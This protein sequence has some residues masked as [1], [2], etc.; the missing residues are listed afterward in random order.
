MVALRD[1]PI[2]DPLTRGDNEE[3]NFFIV[4]PGEDPADPVAPRQNLAGCTLRFSVKYDL[5][6]AAPIF[7]KTSPTDIVITDALNGEGAVLISQD[8]LLPI[9]YETILLADLEV[10]DASNKKYTI[11]LKVPV[12]LDI[13]E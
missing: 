3:I 9:T 4:E 1:L 11:R 5:S 6:D 12:E 10:T 13:T 2:I 7:T 8:D